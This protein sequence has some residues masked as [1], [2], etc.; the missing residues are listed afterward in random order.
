MNSYNNTFCANQYY[1][2]NTK[3][4]CKMS[5]WKNIVLGHQQ[6][7]TSIFEI[8]L[9]QGDELEINFKFVES[10]YVNSD[11]E[12]CQG[13]ARFILSDSDGR[14]LHKFSNVR[15]YANKEITCFG[16]SCDGNN[17][18]RRKINIKKFIKKGKAI[19][20]YWMCSCDDC[21]YNV[22]IIAGE[23]SIEKCVLK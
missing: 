1:Q 4:D 3:K 20:K 19:C 16:E 23:N 18:M 12:K 13:F 2:I 8:Y 11:G 21:Y 5:G 10:G 6:L 9:N 22:S 7:P 15:D 14:T 17:P